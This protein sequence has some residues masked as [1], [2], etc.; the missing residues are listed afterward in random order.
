[1]REEIWYETSD[2][3]LLGFY[4]GKVF[5]QRLSDWTKRE[6]SY[7]IWNTS[8]DF[9]PDGCKFGRTPFD[10]PGKDDVYSELEL[11][12]RIVLSGYLYHCMELFRRDLA[13]ANLSIIWRILSLA[14]MLESCFKTEAFE[15]VFAQAGPDQKD[16]CVHPSR[17]PMAGSAPV[18]SFCNFSVVFLTQKDKTSAHS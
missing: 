7:H 15:A 9:N 2:S 10:I 12:P 11:K 6:L 17:S 18:G 16:L 5:G 14:A 13:F 8:S 1:M 4:T 3:L